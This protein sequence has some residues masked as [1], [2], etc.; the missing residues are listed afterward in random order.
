MK[1][2]HNDWKIL[3]LFT[4]AFIAAIISSAL[5]NAALAQAATTSETTLE[6]RLAMVREYFQQREEILTD[7]SNSL[8]LPQENSDTEGWDVTLSQS[9]QYRNW[10]KWNKWP[11]Y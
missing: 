8:S 3:Q 6:E 4:I 11:N 10:S 2:Q 5:F 7:K 9:N 1:T